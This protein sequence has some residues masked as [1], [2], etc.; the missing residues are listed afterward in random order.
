M[1]TSNHRLAI[2][3]RRWLTIPIKRDNRLCHIF[4][5]NVDERE[6]QFVLECPLYN[7]LEISFYM[8]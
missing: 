7:S 8:S 1:N 4:L 6:A 2:K 3:T 5:Y